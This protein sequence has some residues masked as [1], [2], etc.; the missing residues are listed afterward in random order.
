MH[1]SVSRSACSVRV[2]DGED[3]Q[4]T[5]TEA[6]DIMMW[7]TNSQMKKSR[8]S[9]LDEIDQCPPKD[10]H[11]SA[12]NT[13]KWVS[14]HGR[15]GWKKNLTKTIVFVGFVETVIIEVASLILRHTLAVLT[16][17]F[18]GIAWGRCSRMKK[19]R[20]QS[21]AEIYQAGVNRMRLYSLE[22]SRGCSNLNLMITSA[23]FERISIS[24]FNKPLWIKHC[25]E[26]TEYFHADRLL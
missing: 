15:S 13:L 21:M 1:A 17:K 9:S 16:P 23:G 3:E 22:A 5:H 24:F 19:T 18:R 4:Q 8:D 26:I 12:G 20:I 10:S 14:P 11:K 7:W 6:A 2:L 25:L